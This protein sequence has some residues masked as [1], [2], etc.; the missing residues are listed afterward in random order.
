MSVSRKSLQV[1]ILHDLLETL[2][3]LE[4]VFTKKRGGGRWHRLQSVLL[5][6]K[7]FVHVANRATPIPSSAYFTVFWIPAGG[8]NKKGPEAFAFGPWQFRLIE[9]R[10]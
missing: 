2:S 7:T 3:P 5:L 8:A 6:A 10:L 4:S 9:T 1:F